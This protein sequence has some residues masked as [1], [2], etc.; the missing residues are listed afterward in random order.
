MIC[1]PF[2]FIPPVALRSAQSSSVV[3]RHGFLRKKSFAVMSADFDI[4]QKKHK[5]NC[6]VALSNHKVRVGMTDKRKVS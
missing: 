6:L 5:N 2:S 4:P 3:P 1:P